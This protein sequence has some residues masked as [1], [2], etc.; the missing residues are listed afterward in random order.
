MK[1]KTAAKAPASEWN[2]RA[3]MK[4]FKAKWVA[5]TLKKCQGN[6]SQTAKLMQVT[7][8]YLYR[9]MKDAKIKI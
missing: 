9:L 4:A 1:K 7:R 3:Q 6:K 8:P 2:Y 5:K